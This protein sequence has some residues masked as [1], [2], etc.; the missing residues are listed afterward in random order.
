MSPRISII[1][2]VV[3]GLA[4]LSFLVYFYFN[5]TNQMDLSGQLMVNNWNGLPKY[6][7]YK[8]KLE[9]ANIRLFFPEPPFEFKVGSTLEVVGEARVFGGQ[10]ESE[11]AYVGG[12]IIGRQSVILQTQEIDQFGNFS[13]NFKLPTEISQ[14]EIRLTVFNL[15]ADNG[16]QENEVY[17]PV[18]LIE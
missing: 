17:F 11:L 12:E 18:K 16:S 4:A 7:G 9:S 2:L 13:F 14:Q 5:F 3:V 10:V 15:S 6:E 1:I 8:I